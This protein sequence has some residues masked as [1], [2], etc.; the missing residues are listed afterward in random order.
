MTSDAATLQ[1]AIDCGIEDHEILIQN[2]KPGIQSAA[3]DKDDIHG[4]M[5]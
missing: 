4:A 3:C 2:V 5:G 1:G